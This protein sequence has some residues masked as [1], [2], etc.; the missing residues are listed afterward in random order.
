MIK[1]INLKF[2]LNDKNKKGQEWQSESIV[3]D[4]V[5][6]NNKEDSG[7]NHSYSN[8][9]IKNKKGGIE[10][11]TNVNS[12]D[13]R[14]VI[15]PL[16]AGRLL[17][18][19]KSCLLGLIVWMIAMLTVCTNT[20]MTVDNLIAAAIVTGCVICVAMKVSTYVYRKRIEKKLDSKDCGVV[21]GFSNKILLLRGIDIVGVYEPDTINV[22]PAHKEESEYVNIKNTTVFE[23]LKDGVSIGT[24]CV[25]RLRE[26]EGI[27]LVPNMSRA[28]EDLE[29]I[30]D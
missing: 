15:I 6:K 5:K 21:I 26:Y 23:C 2:D 7:M 13:L 16:A 24:I 1:I 20:A 22:R 19:K 18:K 27:T 11:D 4:L 25:D 9:E 28:D 10:M 8:V 29:V 17:G 30:C 12:E 14:N 3:E